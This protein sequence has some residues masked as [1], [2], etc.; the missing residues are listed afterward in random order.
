MADWACAIVTQMQPVDAFLQPLDRGRA[1]CLRRLMPLSSRLAARRALR[2]AFVGVGLVAVALLGTWLVPLWLLA[3]GPLVWGVPHLLA[4]LRYCV[5]RPGFHRRPAVGCC[6]GLPLLAVGCGAPCVLCGVALAVYFAG[7][8]TKCV[9]RGDGMGYR[10]P[11]ALGLSLALAWLMGWGQTHTD[12]VLAHAHNFIAVALWWH[13]RPRRGSL[14][15]WLLVAFTLACAVIM[16]GGFDGWWGAM[17]ALP[18]ELTLSAHLSL[19]APGL[20]APWGGRLVRLFAFAQAVHY[21]LWL[22]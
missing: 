14:A 11:L 7:C 18:A 2:V 16:A 22:R 19:L 9:W 12:L 6:L 1:W 8:T 15:C 13:W 17:P 20:P 4:D 3:L 5:L 10:L 21:G